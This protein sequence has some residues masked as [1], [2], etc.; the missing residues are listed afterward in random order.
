MHTSLLVSNKLAALSFT[1]V[2]SI[3]FASVFLFVDKQTLHAGSIDY[4]ALDTMCA[5][6]D[7]ERHLVA[8]FTTG[9]AALSGSSPWRTTVELENRSQN[10][11]PFKDV[12]GYLVVVKES[13]LEEVP[14]A[15]TPVIS[16]TTIASGEKQRLDIE[17]HPPSYISDG[18][19]R[20]YLHL[21]HEEDSLAVVTRILHTP[22]NQLGVSHTEITIDRSDVANSRLHVD[23]A[24]F[25][26][27][28]L[29]GNNAIIAKSVD[30]SFGSEENMTLQLRNP[31]SDRPLVGDMR[32]IA[33][34]G[35]TAAG[36]A[37]L[38]ERERHIRV[39]PGQDFTYDFTVPT[40]IDI[41]PYSFLVEY[42]DADTKET[43]VIGHYVVTDSVEV[44]TA[45][46]N[47]PVRVS[48]VG[49]YGTD[50]I[51]CWRQVRPMLA[52][53]TSLLPYMLPQRVVVAAHQ[54]QS[55]GAYVESFRSL[56]AQSTRQESNYIGIGLSLHEVGDVNV[57]NRLEVWD[58][59]LERVLTETKS[60]T[61]LTCH[62]YPQLCETPIYQSEGFARLFGMIIF[63]IILVLA[64]VI[65][66]RWHRRQRL[67]SGF[68]L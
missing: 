25:G 28:D 3:V 8:R 39:A 38:T 65:F 33:Y 53:G 51:A 20:A 55:E 67:N 68:K 21:T 47:D 26:D 64:L 19:Y 10:D 17:W 7:I 23:G 36:A 60:L 54:Q 37:I 15:I 12:G 31:D 30:R 59:N 41:G 44:Y 16:N 14:V 6:S 22:V 35:L 63:S 58:Q 27:S 40:E 1:A 18:T 2:T 66:L 61:T 29:T 9:P 32:V 4:E 50:F 43:S 48:Y 24:S 11:L 57:V 49:Q 34:T 46:T 45:L 52:A 42:T 62:S 56:F 13:D 5:L